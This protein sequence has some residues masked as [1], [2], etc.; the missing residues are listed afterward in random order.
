[1]T[2]GPSHSKIQV[3]ASELAAAH[4][5]VTIDPE[6]GSND[7]RLSD[8]GADGDSLFDALTPAVAYNATQNEYLVVWNGDDDN[9]GLVDGEYEIY[10]QRVDAATGAEIGVDIRLSDMGPDGDSSFDASSPAVAFNATQNEYLVVWSGDD[11]SN[12]LAD[13]EYEIFGQRVDGTSG[14]EIGGD[15]RLSDMGTDGDPSFGA[16]NPAVAYN[17]TENEFLVV[18]T[19]DDDSDSLVDEEREIFGQRVDGVSGAEIG[20]DIRLSNMGSDG[21]SSID[22]FG[23]AVAYNAVQEEFLVIWSGDD[24]GG[25]LAD[26][27]FEIY[28]RRVD[29][30]TGAAFGTDIRLS[31]V[32]PDGDRGFGAFMAALAHNATQNEFL[33]VWT[34]VDDS[35]AL[36]DNE[37]E[38]YGQRV[39]GVSGAAMG[40]HIRLSEMGPSQNSEFQVLSRPWCTTL[41]RANIW[42]CGGATITVA[43]WSTTSSKS[44]GSASMGRAARRSAATY[45]CLTWAR[46]AL[47]FSVLRRRR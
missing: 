27:E 18:W 28:G 29:G 15:I 46:M 31:A 6:I 8:M 21:D 10:G 11:D 2:V 47:P 42:F 7:F 40:P 26:N 44:T 25:L 33:I 20:A 41:C 9:T 19:G 37:F 16:F 30:E 24:D 3:A 4:Y 1:M 5:P 13:N 23:P 39:D 43:L 36:A 45:V 34:G 14:A 12:T 32:G 17:F 38:I 35:S 22:A